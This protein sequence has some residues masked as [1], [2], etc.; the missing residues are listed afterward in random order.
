MSKFAKKT[1]LALV[2]LF[3]MSANAY[4]TGAGVQFGASPNKDGINGN[5]MGTFRLMRFPIVFGFGVEAGSINNNF[6]IGLSGFGDYWI[7]DKQLYNTVSLYAGPGLGVHILS[8]KDFNLTGI[9][10]VRAIVGVD[11]LLYDHYLELYA[12]CGAEPGILIPFTSNPALKF[13]LTFPC[14]IGLRVHF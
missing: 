8:D 4:S 9:A 11:Y 2:A 12:Q 1:I 10:G 13:N 3:V 14:E 5:I 7:L 6:D